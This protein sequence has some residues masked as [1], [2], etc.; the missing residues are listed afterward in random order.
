MN[1]NQIIFNEAVKAMKAGKIG[2]TGR[3]IEVVNGAGE[4]VTMPEPEEIH[5]FQDWKARGYFVKKSEKAVARFAIWNYTT[6]AGKAVKEARKAAGKD[7]DTPAPHYYMKEAYFFTVNQTSAA[8]KMLPAVITA[9]VKVPELTTPEP[10]K[11]KAAAAEAVKPEAKKTKTRKSGAEKAFQYIEKEAKREKSGR[12]NKMCGSYD[13]A[14][15]A[16]DGVQILKTNEAIEGTEPLEPETVKTFQSFLK[17]MEKAEST[18]SINLSLKDLKE[19]TKAL[20]GGKRSVKVVYTTP[21]GITFNVNHLMNAITATGALEYKY[22]SKK[23]PVYF[24]NDTKTYMLCPVNCKAEMTEGL[25]I[26]G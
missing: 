9:T 21:E 23:A 24:S 3:M 2:T 22:S 5:T 25:S 18:G 14:N 17:G 26:I 15:Y 7:E 8:E 11:V 12:Y 13:G 16:V 10:E 20:K 4:V 1:N 19:N 6:K